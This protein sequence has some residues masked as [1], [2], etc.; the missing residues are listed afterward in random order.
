MPVRVHPYPLFLVSTRTENTLLQ[1]FMW[2]HKWYFCSLNSEPAGTVGIKLLPKFLK[3]EE[4]VHVIK[5]ESGNICD[6]IVAF[7]T[8]WEQILS[9]VSLVFPRLLESTWYLRFS[10]PN[11]SSTSK[12]FEKALW[13]LKS[14]NS[15][16]T[17]KTHKKP[18]KETLLS[19]LWKIGKQMLPCWRARKNSV[20]ERRL[21]NKLFK[22]RI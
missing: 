10:T 6:N 19:P 1:R 21:S 2:A 16:N 4:S 18:P 12:N 13:K 22:P 11:I 15:F 14:T 7:S 9:S 3:Q 5:Q 20:W 17:S 8:T